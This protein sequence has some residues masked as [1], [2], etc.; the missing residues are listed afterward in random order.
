MP[1]S[2]PGATREISM[3]FLEL[4]M[5]CTGVRGRRVF[6]QAVQGDGSTEQ[7]E[8][9]AAHPQARA[10]L[11]ST[12]ANSDLLCYSPAWLAPH[13]GATPRRPGN[14]LGDPGRGSSTL[15]L[16]CSQG[17][18]KSQCEQWGNRPVFPQMLQEPLK[19]KKIASRRR[20][21]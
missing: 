18:Q 13:L 20:L 8:V 10:P 11:R 9:T 3:S 1:L 12:L 7:C 16:M 4:L 15:P 19:S 5:T 14:W 2:Q 21:S 17:C 6:I